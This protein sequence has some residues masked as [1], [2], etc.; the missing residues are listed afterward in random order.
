ML[1]FE[2][3][4]QARRREGK[5]KKKSPGA[6]WSKLNLQSPPVATATKGMGGRVV[7][8]ED[9]RRG[10]AMNVSNTDSGEDSIPGRMA[11]S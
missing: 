6:C 9:E 3:L 11:I 5:K 10:R 1:R 2:K 7:E 8:G 4:P